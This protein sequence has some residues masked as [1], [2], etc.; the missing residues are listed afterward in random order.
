MWGYIIWAS[1]GA[2]GFAFF[3]VLGIALF[4]H[5]YLPIAAP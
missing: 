3:A 1:F 4:S 5:H 2:L